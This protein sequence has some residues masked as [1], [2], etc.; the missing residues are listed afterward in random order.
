MTYIYLFSQLN[1]YTAKMFHDFLAS[2]DN[3]ITLAVLIQH[4][5]MEETVANRILTFAPELKVEQ[6]HLISP[7]RDT[8]KI[9]DK[10]IE[11]LCQAS[12]I[13]VWGGHMHSYQK[14]YYNDKIKDIIR[15]KFLNGVAYAGISAGAILATNYGILEDIV[16]KPHFSELNRFNELLKKAKKNKVNYAFGIDDDIAIKITDQVNYKCSGK[17][18]F[19]LFKKKETYQEYDLRIYNSGD[20][21][22]LLKNE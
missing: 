9:A 5:D 4:K 19:Y 12:R 13:L 10:D 7:E 3:Y 17:G 20:K 14:I 15:S 1:T 2:D 16:L 18:Q 22:T 11:V 6:I 8:Y 21:F